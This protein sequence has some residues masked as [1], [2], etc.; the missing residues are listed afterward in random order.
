MEAVELMEMNPAIWLTLFFAPII[1]SFPIAIAWVTRQDEFA[2]RLSVISIFGLFVSFVITVYILFGVEEGRYVYPWL[3]SLG[4]NFAFMV[5]YLSKYMGVLTGI[6]AFLIG[7]Y[8][9]EYMKE[10]YRLGWYWFFFNLFTASMLLVVYSDNLLMLLIGW[11]GL[12]IASWGLIGHWFR[13]D[14]EL[15]YVGVIGRKVGPLDMFWSPK[16]RRMESHIHDKNR[17]YTD[18]L[19]SRRNIHPDWIP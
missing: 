3:P 15:S 7:V 18:V 16:H 5:D 10:D 12:G 13:D 9:Y 19:R 11:E 14:D 6:I 8:G 4:I 2:R 17:R 1:A